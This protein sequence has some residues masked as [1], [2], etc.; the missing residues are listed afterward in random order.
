MKQLKSDAKNAID[1]L[2]AAQ[3]RSFELLAVLLEIDDDLVP[4][5]A[6]KACERIGPPALRLQDRLLHG[7][8]EAPSWWTQM[9]C[10]NALA[11]IGSPTPQVLDAL[12]R[13]VCRSDVMR[14][15]IECARAALRLDAWFCR[16][17]LCAVDRGD[18][19]NREYAVEML[20]RLGE[21]MVDDLMHFLDRQSPAGE[22]ARQAIVRIGWRAVARLEHSG[23]DR[24]AQLAL[25]LGPL[26]DLAYVDEYELLDSPPQP[27]VEHLPTLTWEDCHGHANFLSL[28]RTREAGGDL[29]VEELT[30]VQAW[31]QPASEF[32]VHARTWTIPRER[33]LQATRQL[34]A[35]ASQELRRRPRSDEGSWTIG[36][37]SDT[38]HAR[39]RLELDGLV[40]L[41][42]TFCDY[43][44]SDNVPLRFHATA[45]VR[46]LY[47]AMAEATFVDRAPSAEDRE[48]VAARCKPQEQ[49]AW[50]VADRLQGMAAVLQVR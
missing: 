50:W 36:M 28:F 33:A 47:Q 8:L 31:K 2:A 44:T 39:V 4:Y 18:F 45:A 15:R 42:E 25:R 13:H 41:D 3:P 35:L 48:L 19:A 37:T 6:A 21:P 26:Q 30:V 1:Q 22:V 9:G 16:R 29:R 17:A 23:H 32:T 7:L 20:R 24:L 27:P 34:L 12:M 49:A 10:A 43:S 40:W 5:H 46:V 38:F 14:L 11:A